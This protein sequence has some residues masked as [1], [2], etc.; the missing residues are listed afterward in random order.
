MVEAVSR[1]SS[2]ATMPARVMA[3]T[4]ASATTGRWPALADPPPSRPARDARQARKAATPAPTASTTRAATPPSL[5]CAVRVT[6]EAQATP[7]GLATAVPERM[8]SGVRRSHSSG[9]PMMARAAVAR[10]RNQVRAP[11]SVP[12][13]REE[14]GQRQQHEG[15]AGVDVV[16]ERGP[17]DAS[18]GQP[19]RG[20]HDHHHRQGQ[21]A[22]VPGCPGGERHTGDAHP[23]DDQVAA[24]VDETGGATGVALLEEP[25]RLEIQR[26]GPPGR[27]GRVLGAQVVVVLVHRL[28]QAQQRLAAIS[29]RRQARQAAQERQA[30]VV[31]QLHPGRVG[32]DV[33]EQRHDRQRGQRDQPRA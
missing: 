3:A 22:A 1:S 14:V 10:A 31:A 7:D 12:Q 29:G 17:V 25:H 11:G 26:P 8:H 5:S 4:S 27:G 2:A 30:P 15:Q 19:H 16:L 23:E 32:H 28:G 21:A 6:C 20:P 24:V 18:P 9:A 33:D 13:L